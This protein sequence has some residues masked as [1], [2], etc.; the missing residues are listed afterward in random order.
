MGE[1]MLAEQKTTYT[2]FSLK[3]TSETKGR[4]RRTQP[5]TGRDLTWE[6]PST[7]SL[8]DWSGLSVGEAR[9]AYNLKTC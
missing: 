1:F 3:Q 2:I 9:D 5:T 7:Q 8:F 4:N 6:S